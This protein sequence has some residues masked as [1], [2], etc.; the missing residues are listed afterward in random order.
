MR[1]HMGYLR[2]GITIFIMSLL[3]SCATGTNATDNYE[4]STKMLIGSS[5]LG[6]LIGSPLK[7][8]VVDIKTGKAIP[9]K[10]PQELGQEVEWSASGDWIVFSTLWTQGVRAGGNSEIYIMKYPEGN[11]IK[12][13]EYPYDDYNPAWS[14]DEKK[15][16]YESGGQIKVLDVECY[17]KS[18][19]CKVEPV[20]LTEGRSPDWSSNGEWIAYQSEGQVYM[21]SP[22]GGE[23]VNLMPA[24]PD[25]GQ[26]N[27]SPLNMQ[28]IFACDAL[29]ILDV[30]S[31]IEPAKLSITSPGYIREPVWSLDG[32]KIAFISY[33]EDYGLGKP[34]GG[35]GMIR[36]NAVF[37]I[38][39]DGSNLQRISPYNDEDILWYAWIP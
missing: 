10:I 14:P 19:E 22:Q 6:G 36:S 16:A 3:V 21:I 29:Y 1:S 39:K 13:T 20:S 25:C 38:D 32:S 34:L 15:I 27:W 23:A 2:L 31:N 18:A 35:D 26:P 5:R 28:V 24:S 9:W 11:I 30:G 12:V 4:S 37:I 17:Q 8:Y 7:N 33:R